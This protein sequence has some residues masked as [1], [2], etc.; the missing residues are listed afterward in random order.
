LPFTSLSLRFPASIPLVAASADSWVSLSV[1][2][3]PDLGLFF[4]RYLGILLQPE[5]LAL[6]RHWPSVVVVLLQNYGCQIVAVV[7][8]CTSAQP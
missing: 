1:P 8:G 7:E 3:F 4:P 5:E 6:Q 2:P